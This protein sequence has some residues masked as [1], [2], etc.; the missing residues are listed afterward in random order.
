MYE[1]AWRDLPD[2][3]RLVCTL[4]VLVRRLGSR[5]GLGRTS[6]GTQE[7]LAAGIDA[8]EWLQEELERL[9]RSSIDAGSTYVWVTKRVTVASLIP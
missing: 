3:T 2:S 5:R 4:A 8:D 6:D 9:G 1:Q 7:L